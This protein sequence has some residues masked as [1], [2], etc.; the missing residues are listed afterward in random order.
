MSLPPT[1]SAGVPYEVP[2]FTPGSA[3]AIL[4]TSPNV[5]AAALATAP[6]GDRDGERGLRGVVTGE[7]RR[8]RCLALCRS[9]LEYHCSAAHQCRRFNHG[10]SAP[11]NVGRRAQAR[12]CQ[13]LRTSLS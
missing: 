4:R 7:F 3:S 9:V 13:W 5:V 2:S 10:T 11:T 8:L 1:L 6:L 12:V